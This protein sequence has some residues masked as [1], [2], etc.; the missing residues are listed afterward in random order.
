M[1]YI[2]HKIK[3]SSGDDEHTVVVMIRHGESH[4]ETCTSENILVRHVHDAETRRIIDLIGYNPC[5]TPLGVEQA[6]ETAKHL[7]A[8]LQRAKESGDIVVFCSPM[9]RAKDTLFQFQ[10]TWN[11]P[12]RGVEP[13]YLKSLIEYYPQ[14]QG[15]PERFI[16]QLF[17]LFD[18]L[19]AVAAAAREHTTVLLFGHAVTLGALLT[20]MSIHKP[21]VS[22]TDHRR[23]V[24]ERLATPGSTSLVNS[25]FE[26]SNCSIS[27]ARTA[28][29]VPDDAQEWKVLSVGKDDHLRGA[30]IGSGYHSDF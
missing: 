2:G 4:H 3:M 25:S 29:L 7:S 23:C 24:L 11:Q 9:N 1:Q 27:V 26:L 15:T 18:K 5:L 17:E 16:E 12:L 10:R 28:R 20:L 19:Q 21:G 13:M 6:E 14:L 22:R 30:G 8:P